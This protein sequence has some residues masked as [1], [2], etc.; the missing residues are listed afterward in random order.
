MRILTAFL[1]I[2][3]TALLW[4]LPFTGAI[5]AWQ[6]DERTDSYV[7]TTAA[8]ATS[9]NVILVKELFDN[10]T[11]TVLLASNTTADI[12]SVTSYNTTSRFLLIAGLAGGTTRELEVTYDTAAFDDSGAWGTIGDIAVYLTYILLVLFTIG[13]VWYLLAD[14]IKEWLNL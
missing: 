9:S 10:D 4:L 12:P 14:K 2:L 1:I 3:A 8:A 6:T 11:G 5:Y 7:V 13:G